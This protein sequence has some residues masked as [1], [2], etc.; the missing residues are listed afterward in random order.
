V[1]SARR[2]LRRFGVAAACGL[3]LIA[4]ATGCTTTQETAAKKRAQ[5]ERI[6]ERHE[7]KREGRQAKRKGRQG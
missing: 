1:R 7:Q 5:S 4:L 3:L 6:L 2:K